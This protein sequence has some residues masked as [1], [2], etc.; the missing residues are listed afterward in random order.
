MLHKTSSFR[1]D[2]LNAYKLN[3]GMFSPKLPLLFLSRQTGINRFNGLATDILNFTIIDKKK[4][5]S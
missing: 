1:A 3:Y 4:I 5:Y 2:K